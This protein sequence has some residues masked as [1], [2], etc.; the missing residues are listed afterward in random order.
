VL[1]GNRL[2]GNR[3]FEGRI[4]PETKMNYLAS[5]PLVIAYALAGSMETDLTRDPLGTGN[6]GQ[7]VYLRDIWPSPAEIAKVT[8]ACLRPERSPASRR[9]CP[10]LCI[11]L[12]DRAGASE[13]V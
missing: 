13:Q 7:P 11:R 12:A 1:S 3:S 5:P 4:H 8:A 2:S 10:P 9:K 6:D